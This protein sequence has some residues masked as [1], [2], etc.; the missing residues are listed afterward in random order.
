MTKKE[1][2][3]QRDAQIDAMI[4]RFNMTEKCGMSRDAIREKVRRGMVL[5]NLAFILADVANTFLM[6]MEEELK[7]FGVCFAQTD[8][9]NFKQMLS[10]VTAARKWAE[11]TALPIYEIADADDA[12]ADSDWWYNFIK[13]VDDRTGESARKTN[14]L[15]E[16]L[17]NMPSEVGLFKV[18]YNDFK[19]FKKYEQ[20]KR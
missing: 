5:N 17:L 3:A 13:L 12:C 10:H 16:Y 1:A 14:M 2:I 4:D 18:T 15:L 19:R 20:E 7:P 8:K 9:Y 6:D 11:K